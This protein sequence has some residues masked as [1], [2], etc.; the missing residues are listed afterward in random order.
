MNQVHVLAF[1]G[2]LRK[3]SYNTRLLHIAQEMLPEAMTMEIFD[4]SPLPMYNEDV[5]QQG[6]PE[7]VHIFRDKIRQA[8][9]LLIACPEYNYSVTGALKN[10]I[11]WA[12]RVELHE[13][14]SE[15][16]PLSGKPLGIVGVGGRFGTVRAQ[17]HLRQIAVYSDMHPIN[18]PEV[19]IS[20]FPQKVFDE[21]GNLTDQ[22]AVKFLSDHLVA[23]RDWT[24][25]LTM[26]PELA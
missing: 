21:Q 26:Q 1:S 14:P 17:L 5:R 8:D 20:N 11:D 10:A 23:L 19:L 22:A 25:Q 24:R 13:P 16:S 15:P 7:A 4:L 18:K 9:A 12:S 6:Y 2:S 3:E